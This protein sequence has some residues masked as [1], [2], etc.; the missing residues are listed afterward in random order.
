LLWLV[1]LIYFCKR[2]KK[3]YI[4]P[5]QRADE[6]ENETRKQQDTERNRT[7]T[8]RNKSS[9]GQTQTQ[10]PGARRKGKQSPRTQPRSGQGPEKGQDKNLRPKLKTVINEVNHRL[11]V[12]LPDE[13]T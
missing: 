11:K 8:L 12:L 10:R 7:Q 9:Q 2:K 1:F 13:L 3:N 4:N 5:A 6:M